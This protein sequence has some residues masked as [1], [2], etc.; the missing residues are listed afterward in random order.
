MIDV[1]ATRQAYD[2][3]QIGDIDWL[4]TT[5]NRADTFTKVAIKEG[6]NTLMEE[7]K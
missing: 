6:F 2:I 3:M 5:D 4:R 1:A 7:G